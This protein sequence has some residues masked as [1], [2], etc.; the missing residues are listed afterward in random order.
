M[1][2]LPLP[3]EHNAEPSA[4]E[5]SKIKLYEAVDEILARQDHHNFL[6]NFDSFQVENVSRKVFQELLTEFRLRDNKHST[7]L[8]NLTS[9]TDQT[10]KKSDML[11]QM[12]KRI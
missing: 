2:E 10:K 3:N 6:S 1:S 8:S 5:I 7:Q 9:I 4:L 11:D 12:I